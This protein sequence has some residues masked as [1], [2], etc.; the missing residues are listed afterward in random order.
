[1]QYIDKY[2]KRVKTNNKD[3]KKG[4]LLNNNDGQSQN[5]V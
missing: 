4:K 1:M 3:I 2:H 5:K